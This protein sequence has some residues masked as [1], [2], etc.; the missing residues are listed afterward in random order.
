MKDG[1]GVK[2]LLTDN[3]GSVVAVTD[4][5]GNLVPDSQQ[6]YMPFGEPRLAATGSTTDFSYTGQRA[7]EDVGLMDYNARWYDA[8]IGRFV[9]ADSFVP[10]AGNPQAFNRYAY[11]TNN[12]LN[13]I[14]PSGHT[15]T[16][17][18]GGDKLGC[19]LK[20]YCDENYKAQPIKTPK[21]KSPRQPAIQ[22]N[23][24]ASNPLSGSRDR[25]NDILGLDSPKR[26]FLGGMDDPSDGVL[27]FGGGYSACLAPNCTNEGLEFLGWR[28]DNALYHYA[29]TGAG[30]GQGGSGAVYGGIVFNVNDASDYEGPFQTVGINGSV[31][32]YGLTVF[33]FYDAYKDPREDPD[34]VQGFAIG[35]AP[36][37]QLSVWGSVTDYDLLYRDWD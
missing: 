27:L 21:G 8:G 16:E 15:M 17:D 18:E 30:F 7:L 14:D 19:T 36:G 26:G 28:D 22:K 5:S 4:G 25:V 24:K 34:V 6:R 9:S 13:F 23:G 12:P 1:D 29:G 2:Y 31:G 35:W 33:Y 11:V 10:G 3:L 20:K 32:A 37:G